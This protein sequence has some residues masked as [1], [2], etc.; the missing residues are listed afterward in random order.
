M[1]LELRAFA[2]LTPPGEVGTLPHVDNYNQLLVVPPQSDI[3]RL[4]FYPSLAGK[5]DGGEGLVEVG[6][7]EPVTVEIKPG[8]CAFVPS[9]EVPHAGSL[10]SGATLH[11]GF[12]IR[13]DELSEYARRADQAHKDG[14]DILVHPGHKFPNQTDEDFLQG[15]KKMEATF[16]S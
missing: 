7:A 8:Q 15:L 12:T 5:Y 10:A 4:A 6:Q 16:R 13:D 11:I 2:F 1:G 3:K 14:G 9:A